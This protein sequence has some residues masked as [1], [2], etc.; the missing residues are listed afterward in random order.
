MIVPPQNVSKWFDVG[1]VKLGDDTYKYKGH[2]N[3]FNKTQQHPAKLHLRQ[4]NTLNRNM[5]TFCT[6]SRPRTNVSFNVLLSRF[7]LVQPCTV[8]SFRRHVGLLR[9][10]HGLVQTQI[11]SEP[12][13]ISV[14]ISFLA[15]TSNW[16]SISDSLN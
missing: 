8:R 5:K 3:S 13:D 14:V 12:S 11:K 6:M 7:G 10:T 15:P 1:L 9:L 2:A 4:S 16:L